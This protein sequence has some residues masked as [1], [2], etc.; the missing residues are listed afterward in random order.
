MRLN[1]IEE[2]T[3]LISEYDIKVQKESPL[4]CNCSYF[5]TT[6][7]LCSHL[8]CI[9]LKHKEMIPKLHESLKKGG[10]KKTTLSNILIKF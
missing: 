6:G 5:I 7:L 10:T 2:Y 1:F 8:L 3:V 4:N 9:A